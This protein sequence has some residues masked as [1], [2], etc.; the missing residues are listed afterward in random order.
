MPP[1]ESCGDLE[2][3]EKGDDT[4]VRPDRL[5]ELWRSLWR[6]DLKPEKKED[7]TSVRPDMMPELWCSVWCSLCPLGFEG[8]E[9]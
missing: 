8:A 2:P 6:G 9:G 4:S 1:L 5:L 7:D 3:E